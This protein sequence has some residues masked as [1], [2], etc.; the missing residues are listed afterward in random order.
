MITNIGEYSV[1]EASVGGFA[2]GALKALA[3]AGLGTAAA[4][5]YGYDIGK[6][7]TRQNMQNIFGGAKTVA[8]TAKDTVLNNWYRHE[9]D[10]MNMVDRA[11]TIAG[12]LASSAKA[13][14]SAF[15]TRAQTPIEAVRRAVNPYI[16][17][18][19]ASMKNVDIP[20]TDFGIP[21]QPFVS[22][23]KPSIRYQDLTPAQMQAVAKQRLRE[24]AKARRASRA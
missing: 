17:D 4:K 19:R 6:L 13:A 21:A 22:I 8:D 12:D 7:L 15:G 14:R 18:M 5:Y 11:Q 3:L 23:P 1:K 16:D 9:D 20:D 2:K 24:L 10:I